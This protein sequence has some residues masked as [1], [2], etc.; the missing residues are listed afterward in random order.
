VGRRR[1]DPEGELDRHRKLIAAMNGLRSI[2]RSGRS[3]SAPST[4]SRRW[5]AVEG[6]AVRE[7]KGVRGGVALCRRQGL[8]SSDDTVK[9]AAAGANPTPST[10]RR[11]N[12]SGVRIGAAGVA[13]RPAFRHV[14]I[15]AHTS[16]AG[17]RSTTVGGRCPH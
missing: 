10:C 9:M 11:K 12:R 5:V 17:T 2:R 16:P 13:G 7:G 8:P 6:T 15:P 1:G 4:T 3:R 14:A